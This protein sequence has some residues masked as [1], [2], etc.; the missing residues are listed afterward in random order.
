VPPVPSP[1][2]GG[3]PSPAPELAFVGSTD[4]GGAAGGHPGTGSGAPRPGPAPGSAA[5]GP[6]PAAGTGVPFV[7]VILGAPLV[8]AIVSGVRERVGDTV[9]P[10]AV[11]A[12]AT[13]FTFPLALMAAVL[14][15]LVVQGRLDG[16]DPKLR[17]APVTPADTTIPFTDEVDL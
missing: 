16:R 15:F 2:P 17:S 10:E 4:D 12:V 7:D 14:G 5:P 3:T 13:T 9:K 8:S 11:A 1:T 6:D